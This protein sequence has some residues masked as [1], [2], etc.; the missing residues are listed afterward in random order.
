MFSN[1]A[2]IAFSILV[3]MLLATTSAQGAEPTEDM[4]TMARM[5]AALEARDLNGYCADI[6]DA[7]PYAGYL[8]RVCQ[9]AVQNKLKQPEDCSPGNITLQIQADRKAC[10]AM[11]PEEF[12]KTALRWREGIDSFI[13][14][15]AAQ[16]IDGEKLLQE[17]RA[18]KR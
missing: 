1:G 15:M 13:K 18:R 16:D 5:L 8:S 9:Y 12:E 10:L 14:G 17:E 3:V 6:H 2:R 4:R 11:T 7:P